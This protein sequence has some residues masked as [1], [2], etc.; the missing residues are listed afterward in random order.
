M[1]WLMAGQVFV[2]VGASLAGAKAAQGLRDAGFDGRVVLIGEEPSLPYERPELSKGYLLGS[3]SREDLLVH[4]EAFYADNDVEVMT[5]ASV[6]GIDRAAGEVSIAGGEP[7][8]YDRLLLTTGAAPRSLDI[9]GVDLPGVV[10]LRTVADSDD[11]RQRIARA[12]RVVVVG[13]G[14]IGCEVAACARTMGAQVTMLTPDPF[15]LVRVLGPEVGAMFADLHAEHGVDLRLD[16]GVEAVLGDDRAQGVRTADG[17]Q[18]DGD[19]VVLGVGAA[20]RDELARAAGLEVDDGILVDEFLTTSDPRILAA[21]DV[22]NAWNPVLESRLRVEHWDNAIKQGLA[23]A[24][25]MAG[26]PTAFTQLPF[27]YS[28]QYDFGMEYR[29]H[30]RTWDEVVFRGDPASREFLAFWLNE[31]RVLAAMNANIWDQGDTLD[32]LLR[33]GA[34]PPPERLADPS[35]D[36]ADLVRSSAT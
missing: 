16:T 1:G 2:I 32:A 36:L 25:T 19:L 24:A 20:P 31:G 12:S 29:G 23:A 7:L 17:D 21:G 11:L 30:A 18:I 9:P 5:G 22:A 4:P 27:F 6:T 33:S 15:P 3:K 8:R 10:S 14:W 26:A 28:D 13:A 34:T 35:V